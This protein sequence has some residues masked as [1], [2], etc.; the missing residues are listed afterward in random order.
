MTAGARP[1]LL[2]LWRHHRDE[3]ALVTVYVREA[4]PGER[5]PHHRSFEEK[6]RRAREWAVADR[7]PW[8]VAVDGLGGEVH[9]RWGPLPNPAYLI[10]STGRVAFRALWA[11]QGRLLRR[12]LERLLERERHGRVPAD[13][14]ERENKLVPL[15]HGGAEFEHA[16]GRAGEKAERDFRRALGRWIYALQKVLVALRPAIN[17][18]NRDLR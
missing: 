10:D 18:G 2:R 11:G 6:L 13:L 4:H 9:R 8:T 17:S 12:R 5:I 16:V 3:V 15:I 14:G 1:G 7:I